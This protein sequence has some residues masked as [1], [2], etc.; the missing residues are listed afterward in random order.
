METILEYLKNLWF[1]DA[2]DKNNFFQDLMKKVKIGIII[3]DRYSTCSGG[4]CFRA[5]ANREGAFSI[6]KDME[7]EIAAFTTCGGC[8]GGNI[9]Y[10]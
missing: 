4:K 1:S 9:E 7:L 8:L 5:A 6:Y 3:C 2:S 10:A